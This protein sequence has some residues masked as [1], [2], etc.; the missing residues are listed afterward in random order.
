V[1]GT[2]VVQLDIHDVLDEPHRM[3]E[4]S[5]VVVEHTRN[6]ARQKVLTTSPEAIDALNDRFQAGL[7]L[8]S[9]LTEPCPNGPDTC[10]RTS[11][12]FEEAT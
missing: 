5:L 10:L 8:A 11:W 7:R 1:N 12:H 9:H 4:S 2:D 6:R 3:E